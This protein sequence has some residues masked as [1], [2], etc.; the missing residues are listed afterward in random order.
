MIALE[1]LYFAALEKPPAERPAFLDAACGGD[2]DM[3][4]RV[5]RLLA[6]ESKVGSFLDGPA[7]TADIPA[8]PPTATFGDSSATADFPGRDEHVGAVVGGKYR[9]V[10]EIGEGGMGS[11]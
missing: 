5:E 1:S 9:L 3:R 8:D 4:A 6:A 11:V 7:A 2:A 10:E